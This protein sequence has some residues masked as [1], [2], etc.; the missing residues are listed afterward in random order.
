MFRSKEPPI[1]LS[2]GGSL[3]VPNGGIDTKFLSNLNSFIR[4]QVKRGK[5]F[6]LVT[7]GGTTAR[8]YIDA[9]RDV[10]G[11]MTDEDLD[12]LGIH[13]TR[14]NAHLLRTIFQDIA[15]PRIIE[16]YDKKLA[17]WKEPVV[18]GS[19]WKPGWS[20]DYDAVIL[21]RD[22]GASLIVNLSNIDYVYDKDPNK[23]KDARPIKRLTWGEIEKLVGTKWSPGTNAPFDPVAAQLAKVHNLTVVIVN[24]HNFENLKNIIE[25][26]EFKGTVVRP[27]NIDKHF[28]DQVYYAGGKGGIRF[29]YIESTRGRVWHNLVNI[30][31]ALMIKF[32]INPK[33]CLDV[34]CGIGYLVKWLR[35][36]GVEAYG[37]EISE[38]AI[39]LAKP[40]IRPYLKYAD[41]LKLPY[42]NNEFDLVV[43]YDVLEH[44][45]RPEI[46]GAI[47]ETIRVSS[48]FI[49]HKIYTVENKWISYVH[50]KDYS[51]MSIFSEKNWQNI[52]DK[53]KEVNILRSRLPRLSSFFETIFLLKKR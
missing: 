32:F 26:G 43:T 30:Y 14:L 47:A 13:V 42:K 20:T 18:V 33:K 2:I 24:G 23:H 37:V 39:N 45:D 6:F 29:G 34:G 15:H 40:A 22:Y 52:F 44:L 35:Y 19:G 5:R 46:R 31:R 10:I 12:W 51:H 36:F 8:F 16:N 3:I 9:G 41:I 48:K 28:Y 50:G 21:A 49:F 27:Y 25:G 38:H 53:F 17:N 4:E 11:S 7:G 1:V